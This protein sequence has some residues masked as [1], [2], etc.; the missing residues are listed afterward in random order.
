MPMAVD[1]NTN[2]GG[3][4][5]N[6][7]CSGGNTCTLVPK[8]N[9][10]LQ[11][12]KINSNGSLEID[13]CGGVATISSDTFPPEAGTEI[14]IDVD[15]KKWNQ[16]WNIIA[17]EAVLLNKN[18]SPNQEWEAHFIDPP[19]DYALVPGFP[20]LEDSDG[21]LDSALDSKLAKAAMHYCDASMELL[22]GRQTSLGTLKAVT[23]LVNENGVDRMPGSCCFD[24]PTTNDVYYGVDV[25]EVDG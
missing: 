10:N 18:G 21:C 16:Q 14:H 5:E 12:F 23:D 24:T 4:S 25:S 19:F 22:V 8:D 13:S 11:H 20:G 6:T 1:G 3:Y 15:E 17:H 9:F 2:S 7:V